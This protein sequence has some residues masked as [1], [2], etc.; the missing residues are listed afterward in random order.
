MSKSALWLLILCLLLLAADTVAHAQ[1]D[2][3]TI[4][5]RG[6]LNSWGALGGNR[7][8]RVVALG[9]SVSDPAAGGKL[10]GVGEGLRSM[11]GD[12][13][14]GINSN[15]PYLYFYTNGIGEFHGP[16][17]NWWWYH[18]HMTNTS[19]ATYYSAITNGPACRSNYVWCDTVAVYYLTGPG[20]GSFSIS[21]STNDG[22]FGVLTNINTEGAYAGAVQTRALPLNYYQLRITC[23]SGAVIV[24]DCGMWNE[25]QLNLT[26]GLS[27]ALGMAYNDWTAIPT[28]VTWPIFQAWRPT[29]LLLEAKDSAALF[30]QSFPL[31]EQ[32]FT[33]CAPT[34]DVLYI[35]TT[36]LGTNSNPAINEVV[37]VPQ[38]TEMASLAAQYGRAYWN[39]YYIMSYEQATALGWT[40][41]DGTHFNS[42]GGIAI[43]E[44]LSSDIW[45]EFHRI[46]ATIQEAHLELYWYATPGSSYQVQYASKLPVSNW[47][48]LGSTTTATNV[49]MSFTDPVATQGPR[50]YRVV[51]VP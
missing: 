15:P 12:P 3:N 8:V 6:L 11:L 48:N 22:P 9:D 18:L 21:L 17:T 30:A 41:N 31:L 13:S 14:G 2:A 36:A 40:L 47:Q 24:I 10:Y 26:Y 19:T 37:T 44:M 45:R 34:M 27:S 43:G 49:L 16:D 50:F 39:S 20:S 33:N 28:N 51:T 35:G 7:A 38:N 5:P 4:D 29:L 42:T 1:V 32:M 23:T 46:A 25:H